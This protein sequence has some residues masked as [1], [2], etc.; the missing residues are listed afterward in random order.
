MS[1]GAANPSPGSAP[2]GVGR[3]RVLSSLFLGGTLA[4]AG[5]LLARLRTSHDVVLPIIA[6]RLKVL[7]PWQYLLVRD[8]ARRILAP[9]PPDSTGSAAAAPSPDDL[10]VAEFADTYLFELPIA[11]RRDFLRFLVIVEQLAP[12]GSGLFARFTELGPEDQ[13]RVLSAL[14]SSHVDELRAGFAAVKSLVMLGYYRDP[15]TFAILGY[16]GPFI[17]RPDAEAP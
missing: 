2:T 8:L 12:L 5:G 10:G 11:L 9:D 1:F 15:A 13:D 6:A 3:R 16:R 17:G 14:E 4:I 7:K